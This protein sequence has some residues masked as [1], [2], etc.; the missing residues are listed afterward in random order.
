MA[1]VI[2]EYLQREQANWLRDWQVYLVKRHLSDAK[3]ALEVGCGCGY[4]MSKLSHLLNVSGIDSSEDAVICSQ[5]RGLKTMVADAENLP[6]EDVSFDVVY[7]NYMLM[8]SRNPKKVLGEMFRVAKRYVV[9]FAEPYWKGAIYS[10]PSFGKIVDMERDYIKRLGGDPDAGIKIPDLMEEFTKDFFV[11]TIPLYTTRA[12]MERMI[13][14]E[15]DF[16]R[17]EGYE[18]KGIK[19]NLFYLPVFW[20]IAEK[21]GR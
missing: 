11:G 6:F 16:L 21:S 12:S 2:P 3:N 15:I 4:V 10:P 9:L 13:E 17:R 20:S 7:S 1:G 14:F 18:I 8:W 19:S 5:K